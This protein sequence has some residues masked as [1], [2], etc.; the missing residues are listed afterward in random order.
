[1]AHPYHFQGTREWREREL[2][3]GVESCGT[4]SSRCDMAIVPAATLVERRPAQDGARQFAI[5]GGWGRTHEAVFQPKIYRQ[6]TAVGKGGVSIFFCGGTVCK[7]PRTLYG[8]LTKLIA[9]QA[10]LEWNYF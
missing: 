5:T 7:L 9:S 6:L 1:M 4:L 8:S 10:K 2:D 3:K